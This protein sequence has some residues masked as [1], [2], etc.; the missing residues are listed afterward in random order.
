[1]QRTEQ[2]G[3]TKMKR[4]EQNIEESKRNMLWRALAVGIHRE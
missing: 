1:M 4:A 3:L 2:R